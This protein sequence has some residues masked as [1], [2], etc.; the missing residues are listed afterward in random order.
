MLSPV[1]VEPR[2][3]GS[4]FGVGCHHP[5]FFLG[6]WL[7]VAE[8]ALWHRNQREHGTSVASCFGYP[9]V[10]QIF[11]KDSLVSLISRRISKQSVSLWF[12]IAD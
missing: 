10:I 5:F 1:A 4:I 12:S 8:P 11:S 3:S 9:G 6:C 2:S 7:V